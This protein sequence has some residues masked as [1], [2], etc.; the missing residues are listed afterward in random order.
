MG[1][2]SYREFQCE[3]GIA[4]RS[5][6]HSEFKKSGVAV[7]A[8]DVAVISPLSEDNTSSTLGMKIRPVSDDQKIKVNPVNSIAKIPKR[9]KRVHFSS[10]KNG[11]DGAGKQGSVDYSREGSQM[12]IPAEYVFTFESSEV[13]DEDD[14]TF[15]STRSPIRLQQE[16]KDLEAACST[17]NHKLQ[18]RAQKSKPYQLISRSLSCLKDRGN[19][20][21]ER[22]N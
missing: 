6:A 17:F 9:I 14:I 4:Q 2:H 10:P 19:F 12:N 5:E 20:E 1:I 3:P 8:K 7:D 18:K 13:S 22:R 21:V 16:C 15:H 11:S